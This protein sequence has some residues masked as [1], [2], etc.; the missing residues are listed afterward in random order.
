MNNS[1]K[2]TA[3]KLWKKAENGDLTRS[4][5]ARYEA[6][7]VLIELAKLIPWTEEQKDGSYVA[8]DDLGKRIP[9]KP[10]RIE[11]S[12]T[13]R[14]NAKFGRYK[15]SKK[16]TFNVNTDFWVDSNESQK[17]ALLAHELVHLRHHHH[18]PVF[19]DTLKVFHKTFARNQ[20]KVEEIMGDDIDFEK[21]KDKTIKTIHSGSVDRRS[22]SVTE[23]KE[24][25]REITDF[26]YKYGNESKIPEMM[27]KAQVSAESEE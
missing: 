27:E 5:K 13:S 12:Y 10:S 15:R 22:E 16:L 26:G 6:T 14:Y 3:D 2:S 7:Q 24:I 11:V 17:F 4:Q 21:V 8:I 18:K 9:L 23:R 25:M 20:D 19:W 1:A